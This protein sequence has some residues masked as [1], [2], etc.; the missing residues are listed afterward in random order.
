MGWQQIL[1]DHLPDRDERS[2]DPKQFREEFKRQLSD[3]F[4]PPS[5]AHLRYVPRKDVFVLEINAGGHDDPEHVAEWLSRRLNR[6]IELQYEP[7]EYRCGGKSWFQGRSLI[8]YRLVFRV[9]VERSRPDH[10]IDLPR[11][12]AISIP[13]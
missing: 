9:D 8:K 6:S 13:A 12:L 1:D 7:E 4:L 5:L 11:M 10:S 2:V 3:L